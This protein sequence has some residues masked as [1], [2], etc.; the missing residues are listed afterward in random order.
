[1]LFSVTAV[2][3]QTKP[4]FSGLWLQDNEPSQPKRPGEVTLM[5]EH[6]DPE[7]TVETTIVR[8]ADHPRHAVQRYTTDGKVS[9]SIG[10]DGD[11]F[12]TS[13]AWKDASLILSIEEHERGRIL[14]SKE[15]YS[16]MD[17]GATLERIR[18]RPDGE[19]QVTI[20]R[21]K[22]PGAL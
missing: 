19:R 13:V 11:E 14:F 6:H 17:D 16:L 10:A 15:I 4:D 1:L 3:A 12:H 8:G 21:R 18:E 9:N 7:L 2:L 5:I 22:Q 20:F